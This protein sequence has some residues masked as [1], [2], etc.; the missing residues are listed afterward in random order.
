MIRGRTGLIIQIIGVLTLILGNFFTAGQA[1]ADVATTDEVAVENARFEDDHRQMVAN[2]QVGKK[3]NLAFDLTVG[4]LSSNG[5]VKFDYDEEALN[6]K[7]RRYKYSNGNTAVVVDI[8]GKDSV[9]HWRH[10]VGKTSLDIKLPVKFNR[11]MTQHQLAIAVDHKLVQLPMMTVLA[12]GAKVDQQA[13]SASGNLQADNKIN[14][15]LQQEQSEPAAETAKKEAK[16]QQPESQKESESEQK[17]NQ[18]APTN[19]EQSEAY[20]AKKKKADQEQAREKT[21]QAVEQKKE[22]Q[23]TD[24]S[25]ATNDLSG[26]E[27]ARTPETSR[28][29]RSVGGM[30]DLKDAL[31]LADKDDDPEGDVESDEKGADI[32]QTV[33]QAKVFEEPVGRDLSQFV[34]TQFFTKISLKMD[35]ENFDIPPALNKVIEIPERIHSSSKDVITW[36]WDTA[37]IESMNEADFEILD[38]DYY[39]FKL[40]GFTYDYNGKPD[41]INEI[42]SSDGNL[43][44]TFAMAPHEENGVIVPDKQDIRITFKMT[45]IPGHTTVSYGTSMT[46]KFSGKTTG[47]TFGEIAGDQARID[48][49]KAK[50]TLSKDGKYATDKNGVVDYSKVYWKSQFNVESKDGADTVELTDSF[51]SWYKYQYKSG[52]SNS[53]EYKIVVTDD[54]DKDTTVTADKI[55]VKEDGRTLTFKFDA[56]TIFNDGQK[57]KGITIETTGDITD[58]SRPK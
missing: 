5:S 10:A 44:G 27:A 47:I 8:D 34:K 52:E 40:S 13:N 36:Y 16:E 45:D 37:T 25:S 43:I 7:K 12:K 29:P 2:T 1:V 18:N 15:M 57:I 11:A 30:T 48:V 28:T 53:A 17:D 35:D 50:I 54:K 39:D 19:R 58:A 3:A 38:G 56:K 49:E 55:T 4:A 31:S 20:L 51:G 23:K 41:V 9:V 22:A 14:A 32:R 26:D 21:K 46:T 42:R 33:E 6:I 24:Q